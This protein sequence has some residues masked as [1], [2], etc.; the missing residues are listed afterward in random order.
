MTT[1]LETHA[2]IEIVRNALGSV[3]PSGD[4]KPNDLLGELIPSAD[5]RDEFRRTVRRLVRKKNFRIKSAAI[6]VFPHTRLEEITDALTMSALPGDP[7][8]EKPESD[9]EDEDEDE[10]SAAMT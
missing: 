3:S 4:L 8:T 7:R 5:E 2:S 6:P 10:G 1:K 9:D